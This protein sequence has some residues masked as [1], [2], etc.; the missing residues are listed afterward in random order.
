MSNLK[1]EKIELIKNP[2]AV[3]NGDEPEIEKVWTVPFLS[4]KTSREA[5]SLLNEVIGNTKMSDDDKNDKIIEFLSEKA[6]GGKIT[7]DDI[8]NRFPGPGYT[9]QGNAQEVLEGILFFVA[10]GEQSD[11]TKNFLAGKK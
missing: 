9:D 11:D 8:Y 5:V 10:S 2:E 4:F 3:N 1:R 6:F 7:K